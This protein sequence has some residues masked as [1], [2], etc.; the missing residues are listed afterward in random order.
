MSS[1]KLPL[2]VIIAVVQLT[3]TGELIPFM[4]SAFTRNLYAVPSFNPVSSYC[5][6][7]A[8]TVLSCQFDNFVSKLSSLIPMVNFVIGEPPLCFGSFHASVILLCDT[9][10]T[11]KGPAGT[12]GGSEKIKQY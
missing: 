7:S 12:S 8:D 11:S 2:P 10:K 6:V 4:F 1:V 5:V 9:S 3:S